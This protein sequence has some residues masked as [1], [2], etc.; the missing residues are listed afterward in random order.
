MNAL[1]KNLGWI[2]AGVL[3]VVALGVFGVMV[4]PIYG[5]IGEQVSTIEGTSATLTSRP[6]GPIPTQADITEYE[7]LRGEL[8]K[9]HGET[10]AYYASIDKEF[11][12]WFD[13]IERLQV[14]DPPKD[15]FKIKY[16]TY[17]Q[18]MEDRLAEA[19]VRLGT[20]CPLDTE[21]NP[22][23]VKP[24]DY[25]MIRGFNWEKLG[26]NEEILTTPVMK[27]LQ[28]RYWIRERIAGV[29]LMKSSPDLRV[30]RLLEV[31]FPQMIQKLDDPGTGPG[32]GKADRF[33]SPRYSKLEN[34][35]NWF[36]LSQGA[37]ALGPVIGVYPIG[38]NYIMNAPPPAPGAPPPP[39]LPPNATPPPPDLGQTITFCF[40][41]QLPLEKVPEFLEKILDVNTK[42]QMFVNVVS[43]R[44]VQYNH[45][46]PL[47][48]REVERGQKATLQATLERDLAPRS[49]LL[50]VTG[51][52]LDFD[53]SKT[54]KK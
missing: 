6:Q 51:Q 53:P 22:T 33:E 52:V 2:L 1:M 46:L 39:P 5:A 31:Y 42:P 50:M 3:G 48:Y 10:V 9:I 24:E 47:I 13:E 8:D 45:N 7:K 38:E 14:Q 49:P 25:V 11:E 30:E 20:Y 17:A 40:C 19:K 41:V 36:G 34:K 44:I 4:F 54:Q 15:T 37:S 21:G 27:L 29:A 28:K 12:K 16:Q 35:L 43:T 26:G 18:R 23:E 32:V